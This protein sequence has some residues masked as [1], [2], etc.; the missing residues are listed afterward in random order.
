V[1]VTPSDAAALLAR[2]TSHET[3]RFWSELPPITIETVSRALGHQ[4]VTDA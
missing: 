2:Q 1:A 3:H 4:Q